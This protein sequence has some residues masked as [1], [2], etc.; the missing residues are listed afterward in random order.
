MKKLLPNQSG[1]TLP[2]FEPGDYVILQHEWEHQNVYELDELAAVGFIQNNGNKEV[3]QS[4]NSSIDMFVPLY[5]NDVELMKVSNISLTNC[6]GKIQP[7][8]E[9]RNNGSTN[10]TTLDIVYTVNSG[11]PVTYEWT[12]NLGFLE[13]ETVLSR[14]H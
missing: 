3:L 6:D 5:S 7:V 14:Y 13:S 9:I 8:V 12:G 4:A 2:A 1:V 10:L 11:E